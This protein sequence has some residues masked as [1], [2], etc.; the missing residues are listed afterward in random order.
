MAA[1][2]L[3]VVAL[4]FGLMAVGAQPAEAALKKKHVV[5][6]QRNLKNLGIW[7]QV[8][9]VEGPRTRQAVCAG[10]RLLGYRKA[11]RWRLRWRDVRALRRADRLPKP[12]NGRNYLSVD[13]TC[14]MV[15]QAKRGKWRRVVRASTGKAGHRTPSG[16]YSI[17]W[18]WP[19]WHNSSKYP[20][21]SGNGNMYNSMYF[22]SGGY[23]VHGSRSVPW[24]PASHGCVRISVRKANQLYR[25]T[26][27]GTPIYIYGQN[28]G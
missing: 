23:A 5:Q 28:W 27:V 24:Y 7:L 20:S 6:V 4:A 9:G 10:R 22:K 16:S 2:T 15:Y 19:G 14:Q 1:R 11:T 12:Q 13:K 8:D 18:R 25:S 21:D 17:T 26:P 3:V